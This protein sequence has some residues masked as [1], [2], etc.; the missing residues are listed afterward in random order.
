METEL[1][2]N[3]SNQCR[4]RRIPVVFANARLSAKSVARYGRFGRLFRDVFAED[5]YVA[6]QSAQ[7][8]ERFAALGAHPS[9]IYVVG[10]MKFDVMIDAAVVERGR[11][12]RSGYWGARPTWIAGSTHDGEEEAALTAH[13][14]LRIGMPDALLL[15]VPRH[16]E[17]FQAV[18]DLLNRRGFRFERRSS[19]NSV[20]PEAQVLLVDT[21]GE[22]AAL[23]A[24]ADVAF[25]GGS[26]VA[27]GGHNLLEP[28]A[29]GVPVITGP[30]Y[31]SSKEIA[32]LLLQEG[33]ALQVADAAELGRIL[34][35]LFADPERRHLVGTR[36]RRAVDKNRGSAKR[37][38]EI[39]GPLLAQR[40]VV[41]A[42][43]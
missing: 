22:L 26:L 13:A 32:A 19:D 4:R 25:V 31:S 8:A 17:R 2:P 43:P 34:Q 27:A 41:A 36:G 24:S 7:D 38:L 30:H 6:A 14:H 3:L 11:E 23:Y 16:P 40:P 42:S 28:A 10:N 21:V 29:L 15:L 33:A 18:A 1:W 35:E 37:L 9:R 39:I 5:T 20:R 12:L